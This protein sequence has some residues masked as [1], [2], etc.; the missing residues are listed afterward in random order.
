MGLTPC[1]L[2]SLSLKVANGGA[3]GGV[4]RFYSEGLL[5]GLPLP[6]PILQGSEGTSFHHSFLLLKWLEAEDWC[7]HQLYCTHFMGELLSE[8]FQT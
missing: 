7:L 5:L 6:K 3:W 4:P 2:P 1:H 8:E